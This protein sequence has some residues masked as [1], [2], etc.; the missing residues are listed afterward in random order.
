MSMSQAYSSMTFQVCEMRLM[1]CDLDDGE[2]YIYV[3]ECVYSVI[4]TLLGSLWHG[5][6]FYWRKCLERDTEDEE[7]SMHDIQVIIWLQQLVRYNRSYAGK[8]TSVHFNNP[9]TGMLP[10]PAWRIFGC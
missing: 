9:H 6:L 5:V 1:L 10:L 8:P 3:R 7:T 2:M 4:L